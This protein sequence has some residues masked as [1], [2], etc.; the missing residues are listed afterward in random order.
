[1]KKTIILIL[2]AGF[3]FSV[4]LV[5]AESVPSADRNLILTDGTAEVGGENDS[6]KIFIGVVTRGRTL[7]TVSAANMDIT[8]KVLAALKLLNIERLTLK[9]TDYRVTPQKDYKAKP[10]K[11]MGYEVHNGVAVTLESFTPDRLTTHASTIVA[12]ALEN[13]AN[14][15]HSINFFI[16]DKTALEHNALALATRQAITRAETIADAAGVK[17]KRIVSLSTHPGYAMPMKSKLRG[18]AVEARAEAMVPPME[19]GESR[20]RAQVSLAYEIE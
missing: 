16:K 19:S 15:I 3:L 5:F 17:L 14:N 6:V 10:P 11:I 12:K 9:T 13:G 20:I 4:P 1:M 7:N 18:A 8:D 2:L